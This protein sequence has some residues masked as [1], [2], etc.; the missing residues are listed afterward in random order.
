[1]TTLEQFVSLCL[2]IVCAA[3]IT[4]TWRSSGA[5]IWRR[6][7]APNK[8]RCLPRKLVMNPSNWWC[9]CC[10]SVISFQHTLHSTNSN[11]LSR[12][13][14]WCAAAVGC[15]RWQIV[16]SSLISILV[17]RQVEWLKS[18]ESTPGNCVGVSRPFS[19]CRHFSFGHLAICMLC[20]QA[21]TNYPLHPLSRSIVSA[22]DNLP[23][24]T[25]TTTV[26]AVLSSTLDVLC[27]CCHLY[28]QQCADHLSIVEEIERNWRVEG[29]FFGEV[30]LQI[31][32]PR[33]SCALQSMVNSTV[34]VECA[35]CFN[36]KTL[37][38]CFNVFSHFIS[39]TG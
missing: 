3:S 27:H 5:V 24:T 15:L 19:I 21:G 8:H 9:C 12:R 28:D 10:C 18:A 31:A 17:I 22:N 37:K 38:H 7:A 16:F 20:K 29:D 2:V 11:S 4:A 6:Q 39:L 32:L 30:C 33:P 35:C 1:M 25:L 23:T 34:K 36:C 14:R 26:V 13:R